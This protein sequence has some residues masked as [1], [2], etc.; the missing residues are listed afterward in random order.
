[1]RLV[2]EVE[3]LQLERDLERLRRERAEFQCQTLLGEESRQPAR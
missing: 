1:L 2:A 3:Q